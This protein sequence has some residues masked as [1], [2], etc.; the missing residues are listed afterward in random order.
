MSV[1]SDAAYYVHVIEELLTT[2]RYDWCRNT[3]KGIANNVTRTGFVT[4]RQ[5]EA[6]DHIITERLKHDV[7]PI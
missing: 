3:L 1:D 5:K 4:L 6:I 2:K 7:G